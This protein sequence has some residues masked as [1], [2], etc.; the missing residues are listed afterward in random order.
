VDF[1]ERLLGISPDGGNG[2]WEV[3]LVVA[4]GAL[5]VVRSW[6]RRR[7]SLRSR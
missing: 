6:R 3:S 1:I 5:I 7:S 2:V 4:I